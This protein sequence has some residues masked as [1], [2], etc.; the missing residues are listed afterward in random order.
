[1]K[2]AFLS[3]KMA[4]AR[5]CEGHFYMLL[6]GALVLFGHLLAIEFWL[7]IVHV[8]LICMSLCLSDSIKP[9]VTS[10]LL[11]VFQVT[12][13]H[14]PSAPHYSTYYFEG[15]RLWIVLVLV[16]LLAASIGYY[17]LRTD[18]FRQLSL[19]KTPLLVPLLILSAAFLANGLFF[20]PYIPENVLIGVVQVA[21]YLVYFLVLWHGLS[22]EPSDRLMTFV[23]DMA[24]LVS[25][26]LIVQLLNVYLAKI[27][28]TWGTWIDKREIQFGWGISN[29]CGCLLSLQLP[30]LFYGVC[31]GKRVVPAT[32]T[33]VAVYV[34]I[35]CTLSRSAL[36]FSTLILLVCLLCTCLFSKH[37]RVFIGTMLCMAAVV[38]VL[39]VVFR[40]RVQS[41]F[42]YFDFVG[43]NDGGRF[44]IWRNALGHVNLNP[45]FGVGFYGENI[46]QNYQDNDAYTAFYPVLCH[47]TLVEMLASCGIFGF[48]AYV[49]MRLCSLKPFFCRPSAEKTF[50]GLSVLLFL[51]E[52]LLDVFPFMIYPVFYYNFILVTAFAVDR[53]DTE[54]TRTCVLPRKRRR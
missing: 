47:N 11:F 53:N 5:F 24:L 8:L 36:V 15:E 20:D 13:I 31:R 10:S 12:P 23:V 32:L 43:L 38:A 49:G 52:G 14:S 40:D 3:F 37:R 44:E 17:L 28:P 9:F 50:L 18:F 27:V 25:W 39:C 26:I 2:H 4:Y 22:K 1:M 29:T 34:A 51:A 19:K 42:G 16:V 7:N 33:A 54:A 6:I 41:I 21:V 45:V 35:I 48:A 30:L 46:L